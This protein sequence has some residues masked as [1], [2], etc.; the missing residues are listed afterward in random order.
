MSA[1]LRVETRRYRVADLGGESPLPMVDVP[2]EAPVRFDPSVPDAIVER[3]AS[4]A[5]RCLH[6]YRSQVGYTRVRRE[7]ETRVVVLENE[8]LTA[9]FLPELGGRLWELVDRGTGASLVHTPPAIQFANL[10]LRNAWFAGGIEFNIG[11]RGHSPSTCAPLHTAVVPG[12]DGTEVLRMWE[13]ER[14]RGVVFTIDAWLPP[15]SP[16]LFVRVVIRN[17]GAAVPMY[18]WTNA[19]VAEDP[20]VRVLAPATSAFRTDYEGGVPRV[21]PR[22]DGGVDCTWPVRSPSARD[23]FFDVPPGRRP[24]VAAVGG[25]GGGLTMLSTAALPGRKLFTWGSGP[26]GRRWQRWLNPEGDASYFEIQSGL[27]PT[28]FEHVP[29]G[30]G[31]EVSWTESYSSAGMDSAV[32]HGGD[33][34]AAVRHGEERLATR[35]AALDAADTALGR[36]RDRAPGPAIV[37]G[38]GWGALEHRRRAAAGEPGADDPGAPFDPAALGDDQRPW[39]ALLDS[40]RFPGADSFVAGPGWAA[41]LEAAG[42]TPEAHLHLGTI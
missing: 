19:S 39:L 31:A 24:W 27:A 5:P 14:V 6:P 38:S 21:D 30:A 20:S 34:E 13:L 23:F 33:W 2:R 41:L 12:P 16:S 37:A 9:V 35:F 36:L 28:Q 7:R 17:P 4:G 26:G 11:T 42:G 15:G 1:A 10:A 40:G 22:D 25:D 32:A 8:H 3:A 18:W 29:L